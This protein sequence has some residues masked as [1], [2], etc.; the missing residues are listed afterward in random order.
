VRDGSLISFDC[1][2]RTRRAT[3]MKLHPLH[4]S[5]CLHYARARGIPSHA[6]GS[7][8]RC[9]RRALGR[10]H[11]AAAGRAVATH[12]RSTGAQRRDQC[13]TNFPSLSSR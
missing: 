9:A 5:H 11:M 4:V 13:W 12:T 2:F 3:L 10:Q 1:R 7:W 8:L 6:S